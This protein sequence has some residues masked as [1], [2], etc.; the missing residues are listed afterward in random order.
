MKNSII[1]LSLCFLTACG[2]LFEKKEQ[3]KG[4]DFLF[5]LHADQGL[6]I[7]DRDDRKKGTLQLTGID[8]SVVYISDHPQRRAGTMKVGEFVNQWKDANMKQPANAGFIFYA[9]EFH[10]Y[11][12]F[13][14]ETTAP[15]YD[16]FTN[17]LEMRVESLGEDF[18]YNRREYKDVS[19]FVDYFYTCE[20]KRCYQ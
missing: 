11:S 14:V 6:F 7:T 9:D 2:N 13:P 12:D 10:K 19:L 3:P 18:D 8:R 20:G 15:Q 1:L 4:D 5:L 16:A 17:T